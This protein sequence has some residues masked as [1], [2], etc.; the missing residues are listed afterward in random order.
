MSIL[1]A[2][3]DS[4]KKLNVVSKPA[5]KPKLI[6]P[7][8]DELSLRPVTWIVINKDNY[9]DVFAKLEAAGEPVALFALSEKGYENL[10]LNFSDIRQLVQQQQA[11]IV[12]YEKY[13]S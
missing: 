1:T 13:N 4:T 5:E 2:C 8:V 6:L 10:S 9:E 12:A 3:G 7:K 11:I